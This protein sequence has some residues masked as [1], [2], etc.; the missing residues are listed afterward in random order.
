[1]E[2]EAVKI[3]DIARKWFDLALEGEVDPED[4]F[5]RFIA[6]WVAFNG[7][8]SWTYKRSRS[9]AWRNRLRE[10]RRRKNRNVKQRW[11]G[12]KEQVELF[13]TEEE[14][15]DLHHRLLSK[16]REY[17]TAVS[18]LQEKQPVHNPDKPNNPARIEDNTD[19]EQVLLCIYQVRCNLFHG[20]KM[21]EKSSARDEG[22][23]RAS[24]RIISKLIE[25]YFV[26]GSSF[27]QRES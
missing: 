22:L 18:S 10:I 4:P 17:K 6:V 8:C 27:W 20:D 21:P 26:E 11:V 1:M 7:V 25:P 3:E 16:D 14:A 13:S 12:D 15:I 24:Y 5:L 2:V 9:G 23:V 19:L